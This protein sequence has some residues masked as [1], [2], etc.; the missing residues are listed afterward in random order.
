MSRPRVLSD[1]ER[2]IRKLECKKRYR[3][4]N[5]EK[6]KEINKRYIE[7]NKEKHSEYEKRYRAENREKVLDGKKRYYSENK[8]KYVEWHRRWRAE[9]KE[10]DTKQNMSRVFKRWNGFAP[11]EE[12]IEVKYL[13]N[14]TNQLLKQKVS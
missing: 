8:E 10:K 4:N 12:Y 14:K 6:I 11:P 5:K 7:K 9:N 1:E 2:R 13:I 3:A